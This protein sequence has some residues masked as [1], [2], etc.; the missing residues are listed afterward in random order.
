MKEK[1]LFIIIA[2]TTLCNA[3]IVNIPD[4]NFKARLLSA[5]AT[6]TIAKDLSGNFIDIDTNNDNEIQE[7]EALQVKELNLLNSTNISSIEGINSFVNLTRFEFDNGSFS[8]VGL[9]TA[10]LTGLNQIN[11]IDIKCGTLNLGQKNLLETL[12]AINTSSIIYNS[13]SATLKKI[14]SRLALFLSINYLLKINLEEIKISGSTTQS[15]DLDYSA[16]K[17][18]YNLRVL[19]LGLTNYTD[20]VFTNYNALDNPLYPQNIKTLIINRLPTSLNVLNLQSIENLEFISISPTYN[21]GDPCNCQV[22]NPI[23]FLNLKSLKFIRNYNGI[24]NLDLSTLTHLETFQTYETSLGSANNGSLFTINFGNNTNLKKVIIADLPTTTLNFSG[25]PNLEELEVYSNATY[26]HQVSA[27]VNISFA[28]LNNIK[29]IKINIPYRAN[30]SDNPRGL[31][32]IN[33][34]NSSN[35]VRL[36]LS[37]CILI[38][39]LIL[40]SNNFNYF[41]VSDCVF[42]NNL[43]FGTLPSLNHLNISVNSYINNLITNDLSLDL[44]GCPLLTSLDVLYPKL[45][46]IS[47]KNGITQDTFGVDLSNDNQ[48]LVICH[49]NNEVTLFNG[50]LFDWDVPSNYT[51]TTYC[52]LSPNGLFNTLTGNIKFDSDL[53]GCTST[54][55]NASNIKVKSTL[56]NIN[57]FTFSNSNGNYLQYINTG[58][59]NHSIIFENPTYF[60]ATPSTFSSNFTTYGNTQNQDI[61]ITPNGNYNDLSIVLIP[62]NAARPGF[63]SKYK[64]LLQNKGTSTL[65]GNVSISFDNSKVVY[66]SST[67]AP[68]FTN[69]NTLGFNFS[70]INPFN[71]QE[72]I[73]EFTVNSPTSSNPVNSGDVLNYTAS[74]TNTFTDETVFDNTFILNQTVVNAFDPND[75]TCLE[76]TTVTSEKIGNYVHYIIRFENNGN[77]NATNVVIKDL[78]NISKFDISS[79]F[80]LDASHPFRMTVTDNNKVEFFFEGIDLPFSPSEERYGY[81]VFKIK[82]KSNLVV[83]NSFYNNANIYFDYNAPIITNNFGTTIQNTLGLQE[84]VLVNEISVYP[85]PVKDFLNFKTEHNISKVEVYDIAGRILSSNSVRENKID[86]SNLKTGNYILKLYTEKGIMNTKIIKE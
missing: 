70:N 57:D 68:N 36:E 14:S 23:N 59:I 51:L 41:D 49:D 25:N 64:V 34:N 6:N 3:Q 40:N 28:P 35:L 20:L 10:D 78:I 46:F 18:M 39:P 33:F 32:L 29:K 47:L 44:S 63:V 55:I 38:Q 71:T 42:N 31:N 62:I 82:L 8:N 66:T 12:Y 81:I 16:L 74:I 53:N 30:W 15:D 50:Q 83:G 72:F 61:C 54:D 48:G 27:D 67:I 43:T 7:T 77:A 52:T 65:S 19:D 69:A 5:N 85:N 2:F 84:S 80:P 4:A 22:F 17:Y 37:K 11:Y 24:Q 79:I 56:N 21:T 1:I 60:T 86:L 73:V 45:R 75:K 13:T 26:Y 9:N 58:N 76:G